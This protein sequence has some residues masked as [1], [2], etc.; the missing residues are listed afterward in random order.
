MEPMTI[1]K[2]IENKPITQPERM[3]VYGR[4]K[5]PAPLIVFIR[6]MLLD[7]MLAVPSKGTTN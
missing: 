7:K 3:T 5:S 6:L 2:I 4:A 1:T